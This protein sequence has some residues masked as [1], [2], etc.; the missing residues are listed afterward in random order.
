MKFI[1]LKKKLMEKVDNVYLISGGD[2]FLCFKALEQIQAKLGLQIPDMN[3]VTMSGENLEARTIV[4]SASMFPFGDEYRLVVVKDF[5]PKVLGNKKSPAEQILEDYFKSPN[6]QAVLIFF[7][8]EGDDFFKNLKT[9]LVHVDC[10]KLELSSLVSVIISSF[11]KENIT[12]SV[13]DAKTFALFCNLDMARIESEIQKLSSFA[14][15]TGVIT[16]SDIKNN[17]VEDKEYQIFELSELLSKGKSYEALEMVQ[18]LSLQ[19]KSGFSILTPL[20]NNYRRVLF[21]AI[22]NT[23]RD[24]EIAEALGVKEYAIK[25]CRNQARAFTPRKLKKIVDMLAAA[26]KNIKLGKIKEDVAVKTIIIHILEMR[27]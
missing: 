4:E 3:S 5:N 15:K 27:G 8:I 23:M 1:E 12:I 22:N 17:V 21:T 26:D 24:A 20:Y 6:P 10:S 7:N 13:D 18:A 19:G 14:A 25:M 9:R 2:R 16:E 11:K